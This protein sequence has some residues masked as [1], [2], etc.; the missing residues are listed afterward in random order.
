MAVYKAPLREMRFVLHEMLDAE[1]TFKSLGFEEATRDVIDAI[2]EEAG[3]LS[4]EVIFP[5]NRTGDEEGCVFENGVV[6][7]PSGFKEAYR[8]LSEGG[9][10]ALACDPAYGGQGLPETLSFFVDEMVGSANVALS[11]YPGLTHGAYVCLNEV[12]SDDIKRTYLPKMVQG[13][14]S[15]TMCLTEPHCGTDLGMVKTKAVPDGNGAYKLSGTKIFIT[16][17]EHDLTENIIH[18]VLAK[19]PDAPPGTKGISMFLVPKFLVTE[20]GA[21]GE[22]NSVF[23]G[24]IEHKMGIKGSA[25]CVLNFDEATG[26][27]VGEPHGGLPAMF[28]MMNH[29]RVKVGMQG[30]SLAEVA[31]QSAAQYARERLQ[32]RSPSGAKSPDQPADPIIVHADVRRMLLTARAYNEAARALAAWVATHLDAHRHADPAAREE[33]EDVVALLTPVIKA[34]FSDYGSEVCNLCLQVFGGHGYIAEWG[35]EQLV[36]DVRIAQLYEGANGIQA[37]DLVG[38]KLPMHEGRLV[39]RYFERLER[40][41]AENRSDGRMTEFLDPLANALSTLSEVTQWV[42]RESRRDPEVAA[43]AATDYLRMMG[44]VSLAW[45]WAWMAKLAMAQKGGEDESF[46]KAKLA[47]AR[48]YMQRLLPQVETLRATITAGSH[49]IMEL[50]A[51]AF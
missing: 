27:L 43:A 46:Y 12:A 26:Y 21:P 48:F 6:R 7:T 35:M 47:V 16:G 42:A 40:F 15:A 37:K 24:S 10:T 17:G 14:W 45:M 49:S 41:V 19:L 32:G 44:L 22:R 50:E 3:K 33:A 28:K 4:E 8:L 9:W 18:L 23:C 11:L 31:Y 1:R 20:D 39:K 25:T 51:D 13:A 36:R 34:F 38:R 30:L 29:E 2:L 5:T